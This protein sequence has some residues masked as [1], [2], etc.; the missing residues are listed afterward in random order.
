MQN[1]A[2]STHLPPAQSPEQQPPAPPSV[3]LQGLP[4]V[5]QLVL[6]GWHLPPVQVPLQQVAAS[7]HV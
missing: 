6:S 3:A 5:R 2:P 1:D 4:A 7:V